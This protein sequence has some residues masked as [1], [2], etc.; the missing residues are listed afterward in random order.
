[1]AEF[2]EIRLPADLCA[3]AEKTFAGKFGN[4]EELVT[5]LLREITSDAAVRI[6][7][8]EQKMIEERLKALGYI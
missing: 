5:Y 1:M 3:S 4:I 2:R 6:D 8:A 7:E